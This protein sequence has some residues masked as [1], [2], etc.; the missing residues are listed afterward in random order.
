[1]IYVFFGIVGLGSALFHMTL[2]Y[3]AELFD[4]LPM[5]VGSLCLAYAVIMCDS[6]PNVSYWKTDTAFIIWGLVSCFVYLVINVHVFFWISY[7]IQT[8]MSVVLGYQKCKKWADPLS[9]YLFKV[10]VMIYIFG[11]SLWIIEPLFCNITQPFQ[12]H[13]VWHL[14]AGYGTYLGIYCTVSMRCRYLA[15]QCQLKMAKLCKTVPITHY[16]IYVEDEDGAIPLRE[17]VPSTEDIEDK[18]KPDINVH[19]VESQIVDENGK[20]KIVGEELLSPIDQAAGAQG[21]Q[22]I[23]VTNEDI[24][25]S[26]CK[27]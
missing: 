22:S 10:A 7:G 15:R 8:L 19:E 2:R 24:D 25:G 12:L 18:A 14:C 17:R 21:I 5:M 3:W 27:L 4:V 20:S 9:K 26:Y 16:L 6:K 13:A 1:M 11:I 23:E